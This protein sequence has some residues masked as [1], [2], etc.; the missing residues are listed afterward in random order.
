M[1]AAPLGRYQLLSGNALKFIAI[2]T[3]L[4]DHIGAAILENQSTWEALGAD[5]Q[6]LDPLFNDPALARILVADLLLRG[7]GRIAFPI[8]CFLLVEGFLHT[9]SLSRYIGRMAALAVITEVPFDLAFFS[10][11]FYWGYQSIYFTLI[12]G[13]LVMAALKKYG[14]NSLP[15]FL[16]A[17]GCAGLAE[18]IHADYGAFGVVLILIFYLFRERRTLQTVIGCFALCWEITAPLAFLPIRMYN[19]RRGKW[20]LK[21]FFYLFY[22]AHI[23]LLYLVRVLLLGS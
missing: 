18:V 7:L 17:L 6:G 4:L 19:G 12:L 14:E 3:M 10:V 11:P 16:L 20:N 21:Y 8:F 1:E 23:L 9:R 5:M 15:G 2:V 13:L 22:P